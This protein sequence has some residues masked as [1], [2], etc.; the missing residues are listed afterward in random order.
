MA[1]S[2][3]I[4]ATAEGDQFFYEQTHEWKHINDQR[5]I[6]WFNSALTD[7]AQ[8]A[9][10]AAGKGVGTLKA[11]FVQ[12]WD[13]EDPLVLEFDKFSFADMNKV[14]REFIKRYQEIVEISE[15]RG[16]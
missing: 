9:Q 1:H 16:K 4:S 6:D 13:Q 7:L 3:Y 8:V 10:K 15:K 5:A 14:H 2:L 11:T 12:Q